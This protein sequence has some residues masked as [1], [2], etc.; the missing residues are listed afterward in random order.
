MSKR[1]R[2]KKTQYYFFEDITNFDPNNTKID[3]KS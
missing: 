1:Y 2:F 3:G